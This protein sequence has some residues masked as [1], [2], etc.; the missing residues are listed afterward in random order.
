MDQ[1][2]TTGSL[3]FVDILS[4]VQPGVG[5]LRPLYD[6]VRTF[7][8]ETSATTPHFLVVFDGVSTL[9]WLG[10]DATEVGRLSRAL[11]SLCRKV[12]RMAPLLG[13]VLTWQPPVFR[14][15]ALEIPHP[16]PRNNRQHLLS[17]PTTRGVPG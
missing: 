7:I 16:R 10:F 12:L 6:L 8:S 14:L 4:H 17:L 11:S 2:I 1:L 9:E 13:L 5:T 15:A 3:K